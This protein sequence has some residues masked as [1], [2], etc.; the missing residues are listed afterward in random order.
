MNDKLTRKEFFDATA[1]TAV[2]VSVGFFG[3]TLLTAAGAAQEARQEPITVKAIQD[4]KWPWPYTPLDPEDIRKRGHK[5]YYDGGCGYGAFNALVSA[6]GEKFGE[7]YT[8]MPPQMLYFGGGGGAG[9]G[10]L[11][12]ALN[13]AAAAISLVVDRSSASSIV[14]ELFGWYTNALFPSNIS[15]DYATQHVFLV[16]R[17]DKALVQTKSSTPLCHGS[18]SKWCTEAKLKSSA[19]ERAER[20]ARLTGDTVARAVEMLNAFA[21]GSFKAS[22]VANQAVS[23]CMTCHDATYGH[24]ISTVKMDCRQ[25]HNDTWDHLF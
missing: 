25:C 24:V 4:Y 17:N 22:F 2:G 15:N 7:P 5:F 11:C 20:C 23:E 14:S 21:A 9:W 10:T 8:L 1:R 19:P 6:L 3:G 18:V 13:G 12:G 16:N